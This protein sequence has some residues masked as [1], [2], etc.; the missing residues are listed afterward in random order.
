M[1]VLFYDVLN[2]R[3]ALIARTRHKHRFIDDKPFFST[4][5]LVPS[6]PAYL[7]LDNEVGL[8]HLA[9]PGQDWAGDPS[10]T[11][12]PQTM[13]IDHVTVWAKTKTT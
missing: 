7:V 1:L 11:P 8:G 6:T 9:P 10:N 12:F 3:L 5:E 2:T 4:T 13:L